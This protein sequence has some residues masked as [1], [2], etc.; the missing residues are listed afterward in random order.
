MAETRE[1]G[2]E[3]HK[4]LQSVMRFTQTQL[5]SNVQNL[6]FGHFQLNQIS[7]TTILLVSFVTI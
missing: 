7:N 5:T 2:K 4:K 1:E 6:K 3:E